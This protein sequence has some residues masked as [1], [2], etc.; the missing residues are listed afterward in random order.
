M[1]SAFDMMWLWWWEL[2]TF[3]ILS[4]QHWKSNFTLMSLKENSFF[5]HHLDNAEQNL[6]PWRDF[7]TPKSFSDFEKNC[8][9]CGFFF[10]MKTFW[11]Y[12]I[13]CQGWMAR[14]V[15]MNEWKLLLR[16]IWFFREH[17]NNSPLNEMKF[18]E[19][20]TLI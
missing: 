18:L 16:K 20:L 5:S 2:K 19:T 15:S 14:Y 12:V 3:Q 13:W 17:K 6:L 11:M 9:K 4:F 8:L 1:L 7:N 10:V